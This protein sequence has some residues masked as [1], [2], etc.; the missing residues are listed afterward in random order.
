MAAQPYHDRPLQVLQVLQVVRPKTQARRLRL[1][2]TKRPERLV[3]RDRQDHGDRP[4]HQDRPDHRA[5]PDHQDHQD[6]QDQPKPEVPE[7]LLRQ[8]VLAQLLPAVAPGR[9][10]PARI[11]AAA[12]ISVPAGRLAPAGIPGVDDHSYLYRAEFAARPDWR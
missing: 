7:R 12:V 1:A 2:A 3:R 9:S 6:H 5:R 11:P 8:D 10:A 4:D